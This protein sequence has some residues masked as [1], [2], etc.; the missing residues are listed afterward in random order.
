MPVF[1]LCVDKFSF[2]QNSEDED[3]MPDMSPDMNS[4]DE[5]EGSPSEAEDAS[6]PVFGS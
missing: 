4:C 3:N 1:R 6:G 5:S 2:F